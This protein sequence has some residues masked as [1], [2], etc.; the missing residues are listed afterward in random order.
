MESC[1]SGML[2]NK[3]TSVAGASA[4]FMGSLLTYSNQLKQNLVSV[5]EK[6]LKNKGA[7]SEQVAMQM[8]FNGR[9][10]LNVDYCIS[11]TGIAGPGGATNKKPVG[12]V[13]IGLASK[14]GVKAKKF[15]FGDN[16]E[17]N[18]L[19]TSFSALNWLR[20]EL[21]SSDIVD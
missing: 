8:A 17:R 15:N 1:T 4:Y 7:V 6:D 5:S 16:R 9:K 3:I 10:V 21:L 11:T 20:F 13:W 2:A 18:M 14:E 12:L 19:R